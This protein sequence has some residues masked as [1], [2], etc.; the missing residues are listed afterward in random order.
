MESCQYSPD[1]DTVRRLNIYI[2]PENVPDVNTNG[3]LNIHTEPDNDREQ[4]K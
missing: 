3:R 2:E 4:S 1:A